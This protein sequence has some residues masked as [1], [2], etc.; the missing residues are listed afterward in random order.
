MNSGISRSFVIAACAAALWTAF[1]GPAAAAPADSIKAGDPVEI[2]YTC[3]LKNGEIAA[4]TEQSVADDASLKKSDIFDPSY[5][6]GGIEMAAGGTPGKTPDTSPSNL[7]NFEAQVANELL[8]AV[9]R[10]EPGEYRNV[11]LKMKPVYSAT[12][13]QNDLPMA[14]VRKR[15]K[16]MTIP[17]SEYKAHFGGDAQV[18]AP[19][20]RDPAVPGKVESVTESNVIVKF[21]AKPGTVVQTP[22]GK[23]TI[24]DGGDHWEIVIDAQVGRLLRTGPLVGRISQI[25]KDVFIID[26]GAPFK[27]EPLQCDF[28]VNRV[29]S[30]PA[31]EQKDGSNKEAHMQ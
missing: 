12:P 27:D 31:A 6:R 17:L 4:T 1:L 11:E 30:E 9:V 25:T 2:H 26:F 5:K 10:R 18:G 20:V 21:E 24:R 29:K 14:L 15:P 7:K 13:G 23:G 28:T 22:V 19:Y 16:E 3:R 8:A